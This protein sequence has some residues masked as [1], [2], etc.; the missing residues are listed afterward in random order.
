MLYDG[1]FGKFGAGGEPVERGAG[2]F[3]SGEHLEGVFAGH[4]VL[5]EKSAGGGDGGGGDDGPATGAELFTVFIQK[6]DENMEVGEV[7]PGVHVGD[8][9]DASERF[10]VKR[11]GPERADAGDDLVGGESTGVILENHPPLRVDGVAKFH[12]CSRCRAKRS[13]VLRLNLN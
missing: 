3:P 10:V 11:I 5:V 8:V 1:V 9:H 7:W 2:G 4:G 6:T 13:E 12:A